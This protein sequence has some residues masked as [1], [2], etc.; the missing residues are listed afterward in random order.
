MTGQMNAY[1]LLAAPLAPLA[2]AIAAGMAG[3][4]LAGKPLS[5][6]LACCLAT[7]GVALSCLISLYALYHTAQGGVLCHTFYSWIH[8]GTFQAEIGLMVDSLTALMMGVVTFVS[9]AVHLYSAGYMKAE[10][11][12]S[13]FF[14]CTAFFTFAMLMLVMAGNFL[15]LFFGWEAVGLASYLLIGFRHEKPA[16]AAAGMRAFLVN[17]ISDAFFI[18]GIGLLFSV[19]ASFR[20]GDLFA[21]RHAIA[22]MTLPGT[23][24]NLLTVACLCLFIGAMGKSAQFPLHIWLPGSM[25]GPTPVS[26]LIHAATMVTAGIFMVAR[27][28]PLFSLSDAAL[29]CMLITGALTALF[30]GLVAMAQND[31]KQAIAYSTISQLG[32]MTAA[33]G[34]SAFGAAIFHLMTHA[35]F[36]ALLFLAAGAVITAMNHDQDIRH[37]GGLRRHMPIT[38]LASLAASLSLAGFPLFSGFYSKDSILIALGRASGRFG[39]SLALVAAYLGIFVTAFYTFRLFFLVFHG[40]PRFT[41][42]LPDT[43]GKNSLPQ[44]ETTGLSPEETPHPVPRIMSVSLIMLVIPAVIIG[45]L[46]ITPLLAGDFLANA[47]LDALFASTGEN[48]FAGPAG[49][50]LHSLISPSFLMLAAGIAAAAWLYLRNR[51]L[52]Q[53]LAETLPALYRLLLNQYYLPLATE[54]L[55][56]ALFRLAS[57]LLAFGHLARFLEN[58]ITRLARLLGNGLWQLGEIRIIDG[59]FVHGSARLAA[60]FSGIIRRLQSGYLY[61]YAF[62]MILGLLCLLLYFC[63]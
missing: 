18:T 56:S 54:K 30:M 52:P 1:L 59:L 19:A 15:Q 20:F 12:A 60:G 39:G 48:R 10:P 34:A 36:K 7:A 4:C 55:R 11:G 35:F 9:L 29:S 14:A 2:G 53:K 58:G 16:A 5:A 32:Y 33:L 28:S 27:L 37:M 25:E 13:R 49:M 50:A 62:V 43:D 31:I 38:W 47:G 8:S 6:R 61:H 42:V 22:A 45:G 3:T 24:W 46:A 63:R 44:A 26:A 23:G 57:C 40:K 41:P 17:R 51:R 21:M